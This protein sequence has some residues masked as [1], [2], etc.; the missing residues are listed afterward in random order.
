VNNL[1]LDNVW[2]WRA[3]HDNGTAGM[4]AGPSIPRKT[5]SRSIGQNV[6]AYGLFVE[7]FQGFQTLWNG[8]GGSVYFYQSEI[9]T[10]SQPG[11]VQQ[12]NSSEGCPS[13]DE[14]SNDTTAKRPP[15]STA[16]SSK[17]RASSIYADR[18]TYGPGDQMQHMV[19]HM[20]W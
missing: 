15:V 10:T 7:H 13:S 12:Q 5:A 9:P 20:A 8:N 14:S 4:S 16:I 18:D 6:T 2:L 17:E 11:G 1:I 3:D 19:T